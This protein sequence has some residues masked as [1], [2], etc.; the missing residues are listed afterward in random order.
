MSKSFD[1]SGQDAWGRIELGK[2]LEPRGLDLDEFA[3]QIRDYLDASQD[4]YDRLAYRN[5]LAACLGLDMA[6]E[7]DR[8]KLWKMVADRQ[9]ISRKVRGQWL[10]GE[11]DPPPDAIK[12][13]LFQ[14]ACPGVE[15]KL[16]AALDLA[17]PVRMGI[18]R[19]LTYIQVL[20][21][22]ETANVDG[23]DKHAPADLRKCWAMLRRHVHYRTPSRKPRRDLNQHALDCVQDTFGPRFWLEP[24]DIGNVM[25]EVERGRKGEHPWHWDFSIFKF[26]TLADVFSTNRPK[27]NPHLWL[28]LRPGRRAERPAARFPCRRTWCGDAR[29]CGNTW[30]AARQPRQR[31]RCLHLSQPPLSGGGGKDYTLRSPPGLMPCLFGP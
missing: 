2:H 28:C 17:A 19:T 20:P 8:D 13:T 21:P 1:E 23:L 31:P 7:K 4:H 26:A 6:R 5:A 22:T 11:I 25:R 15:S 9:G 14:L 16:A 29:R 30:P 10:T 27:A 18:A 3:A 12:R 24:N